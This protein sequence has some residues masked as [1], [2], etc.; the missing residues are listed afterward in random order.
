[1][2]NNWYNTNFAGLDYVVAGQFDASNYEDN[3]D[4]DNLIDLN[5][6]R[7]DY[8][9]TLTVR[10]AVL[11]SKDITNNSFLNTIHGFYLMN[12]S[13]HSDAYYYKDGKVGVT[14]YNSV[15]SVRPVININANELVG[16]GTYNNPYTIE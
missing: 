14:S 4:T 16:D 6:Y 11:M 7:S 10:E 8:V 2:V 5:G 12:A 15:L 3:Y 9:G 1:M 13:G